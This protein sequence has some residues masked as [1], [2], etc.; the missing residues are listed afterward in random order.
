MR[1]KIKWVLIIGI[2]AML[3]YLSPSIYLMAK[4][5]VIESGM[6]LS[7]FCNLLIWASLIGTAAGWVFYQLANDCFA[8]HPTKAGIS[9]QVIFYT[10]TT[11]GSG[12]YSASGG[13]LYLTKN[14]LIFKPHLFS[15]NKQEAE[16]SI[17]DITTVERYRNLGLVNNGIKVKTT[18]TIFYFI[19]YKPA[20]WIS[21]IKAVRNNI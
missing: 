3:I 2:I 4:W 5:G 8:V 13:T 20:E 21:Q 10:G 11:L 7:A 16:I 12:I 14:A 18:N 17:E 6:S 15:I 1:N 9:E 19:V